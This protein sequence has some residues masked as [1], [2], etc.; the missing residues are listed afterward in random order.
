MHGAAEI[1]GEEGMMNIQL[2]DNEINRFNSLYEKGCELQRSLIILDG[3]PRKRLGL[4]GRKKLKKSIR[5]F[6]EALAIHPSS[7][8][9]MFFIGKAF[10]ALGDLESAL[11]WFVKTAKF[12]PENPSVA[13]EAGLCA[14]QLGKHLA[15]IRFM[16]AAAAAHPGDAALQCN[17]GLSYLMSKQVDEARASFSQ[18]VQAQPRDKMNP[19]LLKLAEE[20]AENKVPCPRSEREILEA[21]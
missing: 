17:I 16:K 11:P 12:E 3:R 19:R 5:S 7:W 9:S 10:Q 1:G 20:V 21:I 4:F 14:A 2:T 13:K 18:A 8:Q 15:A 6:E